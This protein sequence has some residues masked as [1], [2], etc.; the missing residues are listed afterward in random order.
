ME[1]KM[2]A[3]LPAFW[4]RE[5]DKTDPFRAMQREFDRMMRDFGT[6]TPAAFT[7]GATAQLAP[8][9]DISESDDGIDVTAEL[10]GVEEDDV[11]ITLTDRMLTIK[12]EKKAETEKKEKDYHL[13]ERSYGSFRRSVTLPFDA[14]PKTVKAD[15]DKGVLKIHL[16]KPAEKTKASNRIAIKKG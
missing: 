10:P 11:E 7:G 2:R 9:I 12:G 15:F 6:T 14:D 1:D 16:P 3:L 8:L 4:G 5:D 13:V